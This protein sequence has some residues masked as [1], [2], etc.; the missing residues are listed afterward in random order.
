MFFIENSIYWHFSKFFLS[1]ARRFVGK[2]AKARGEGTREKKTFQQRKEE[3]FKKRFSKI[4]SHPIADLSNI[5]L[6]LVKTCQQRE[7]FESIYIFLT[8]SISF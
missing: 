4:C 7:N 5:R 3:P 2:S 8:L 6:A 1:S